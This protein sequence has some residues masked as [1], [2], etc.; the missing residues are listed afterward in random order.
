MNLALHR[1]W[2]GVME[3]GLIAFAVGLLVFVVFHRLSTRGGWG[4]GHAIG[5]SALAAVVIAAGVDLWLLFQMG[6]VRLESPL[7][8]RVF[9]SRIHDPDFLHARV[10]VEVLLALGG[11]VA[12][13]VVAESRASR[14]GR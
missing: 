12:G 7:R 14:D 2:L 9:L 5:W 10:V 13:W 4:P 1:G 8:A 11:A 6:V 3:A